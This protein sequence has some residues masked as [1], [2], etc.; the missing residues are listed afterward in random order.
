M[1]NIKINAIGVELDEEAKKYLI[2]K[3]DSLRK[4]IDLDDESVSV[5]V[6][7]SKSIRR[8]QSGNLYRVE[9]S[10]LTAGKKCGAKA[11]ED[12]LHATF[13]A[14]KD[15]ISQKISSSKGRKQSLF[16]KGGAKIKQ[17]LKRNFNNSKENL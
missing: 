8:H 1:K 10:I 14:L 12:N 2:K 16:K 17:L 5:D 13:D 6:R 3:L 7:I 9:A 15:A 4:F 11:E